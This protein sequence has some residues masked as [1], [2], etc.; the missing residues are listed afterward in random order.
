MLVFLVALG[1]PGWA[2]AQAAAAPKVLR[3]TFLGSETGFDPP[4]ISDVVSAAIVS[5]LFDAPLT[6]DYL[7][8]PARLKPNTVAEMP[9]VHDNHTR[10]VFRIKPGI[11]FTEHP[12]FQGRPRELVAADYVYS[13]KRYY[14]PVT[15]SPT[16]FQWENVGLLGLSE[17]R[18]QALA[19]KKPFDYDTE[20][21]GI[22]ALD[23][24]RFE[25]RVAQPAP[26]LPYL[27]ATPAVSGAVAREVIEAHPGDT[28][29]HPV[30]TGPFKLGRWVRSSRIE[31]ERNPLH[32]HSVHDEQPNA[33]DT[34]GQAIAQQMR[35]RKLPMLD[36]V[37]VA[38]IEE[39]QP[40]WL[41]FL[42][43]EL[44]ILWVPPEFITRAAPN[45]RLAPNLAK[46]GV[47]MRQLV[48]PITRHVYFGMEHPMVGGLAPE[49]VALRRA[50]GLA[51][52]VQ[53]E[54]ELVRHGQ[55][56]AA[57][58]P[59]PPGVSGYDPKLRSEMGT[60]DPARAKALLDLYGYIDRDGDGWREN[61]DGSPLELELTTEP[62]QLARQLQGLWQ[63]SLKAVGVKISFRIGAWPENIKAS[64]AGKLMMWTT[65][66][67]AAIPDG[68]YFMDLLYGPNKG[69]SNASRFN[70]PA[71]N[72][73]HE[74]QRQLPDGPERDALVQ[75]GMKIALAYMP[76]KASGHDIQTWVMQPRVQGYMPHPFMRDFW[77]HVD[78][79]PEP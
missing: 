43:G 79:T 23:R 48:M 59:I 29:R 64:R 11:Y 6:Y 46:Q 42:N 13:I 31:L 49:K 8:R 66:W 69:Q 50:V 38:I 17:L 36:R 4:Q 21:A 28:M 52:D 76:Y 15:R 73:L 72:A 12:A 53:R 16:M 39:A 45:N 67:S 54:I 20:V 30:G 44:D 68:T 51:Y 40:R 60:H 33:D 37:E 35:G 14:D 41:A 74:R 63:K 3:V 22:R 58:A 25:V 75:Q 56:V 78:L 1:A 18:K 27:F 19:T 71:F 34:A 77:R 2:G 26:R 5:S 65:G 47:Q 62:T 7:A 10:F 9:E 61:P 24:Y 57:Q 55:M 32:Q 70:L